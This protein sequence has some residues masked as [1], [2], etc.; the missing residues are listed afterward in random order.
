MQSRNSTNRHRR[1]TSF[2]SR[3]RIPSSKPVD[4]GENEDSDTNASEDSESTVW[5]AI[6]TS[7][8][9]NCIDILVNRVS[10]QLRLE[11]IVTWCLRFLKNCRKK[12]DRAQE[13]AFPEEMWLLRK[14]MVVSASSKLKQF[15][16]YVDFESG[17]FVRVGGRLKSA[18][19]DYDSQH[20]IAS[21]SKD[22]RHNY[23]EP[24]LS[25]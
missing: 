8:C 2:P 22:H 24:S 16:P 19:V 14:K 25:T 13:I 3:T 7:V 23:L 9:D 11:R 18:P 15:T 17:G 21:W 10:S 5:A 20:N 12:S 6:D 4:V 1:V